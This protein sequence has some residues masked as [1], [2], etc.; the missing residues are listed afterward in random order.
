[1][2]THCLTQCAIRLAMRS[3]GRLVGGRFETEPMLKYFS[4]STLLQ[5]RQRAQHRVQP[6]SAGQCGV[7]SPRETWQEENPRKDGGGGGGEDRRRKRRRR[8]RGRRNSS[9]TMPWALWRQRQQ[10]RRV[11]AGGGLKVG[12]ACARQP[13]VDATAADRVRIPCECDP[14]E[15]GSAWRVVVAACGDSHGSVRRWR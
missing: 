6:A 3:P 1:M 12:S 13:N 7:C 14:A 15:C 8:Q 5:Q 4:M 10:R 11:A 2:S 9:R